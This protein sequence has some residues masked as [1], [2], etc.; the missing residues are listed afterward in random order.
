MSG[1]V[2][3][4]RAVKHWSLR[5]LQIKLVEIGYRLVRHARRLVFQRAEVVVPRVLFK[6]MIDRNGGLFPVPRG[7]RTG[8]S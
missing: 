6:G 1:R 3:R 5:S 4:P 7:G 8:C 2:D